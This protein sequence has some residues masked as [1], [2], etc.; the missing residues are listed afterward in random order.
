M[1]NNK[2]RENKKAQ[3]ESMGFVMIVLILI[4][5]AVVFLA[6]ALRKPSSSTL[7]QQ[8]L[9]DLTWAVLSYSTNCTI[10]GEAKDVYALAKECDKSTSVECDEDSI[11]RRMSACNYL[12][13]TLNDTL[14]RLLGENLSLSNK[15]VHAYSF[16]VEMSR[17]VS[18]IEYGNMSYGNYIRYV[19]YIPGRDFDINVSAKFYF[20]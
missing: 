18:T 3:E 20:E 6:F 8:E 7:K 5:I 1:I 15:Q 11:G 2:S 10:S 9:A 13:Y 17:N 19:T 14:Y 12:K 4:V 16:E